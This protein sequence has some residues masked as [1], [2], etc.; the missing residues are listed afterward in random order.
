M[1]TTVR[2][3]SKLPELDWSQWTFN[4]SKKIPSFSKCG[5]LHTP[6]D[7][8][9][10][11][12]SSCWIG[13]GAAFLSSHLCGGW[14]TTTPLKEDS[15]TWPVTDREAKELVLK[16]LLSSWNSKSEVTMW[17]NQPFPIISTL[18]TTEVIQREYWIT[19]GDRGDYWYDL[20]VHISLYT[21]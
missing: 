20:I 10:V 21:S 18:E 4:Y 2:M 9:M 12:I 11:Q 8:K 3:T 7:T 5:T 13:F 6:T 1:S 16:R 14:V 19:E 17:G 15:Q